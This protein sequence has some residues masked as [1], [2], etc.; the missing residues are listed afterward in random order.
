[1]SNLLEHR[2]VVLFQDRARAATRAAAFRAAKF[3]DQRFSTANVA[4][5]RQAT[6]F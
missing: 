2:S 5:S 4:R 1:M 3:A 6:S